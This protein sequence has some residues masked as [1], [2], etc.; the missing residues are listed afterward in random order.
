M[1]YII[2]V[3]KLYIAYH[4]PQII[5]TICKKHPIIKLFHFE[6]CLRIPFVSIK[7]HAYSTL[8]QQKRLQSG[9]DPPACSRYDV[10]IRF[11]SH[12]KNLKQKDDS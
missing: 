4:S 8:K 2:S 7:R 1:N 12:K 11:R 5:A 3:L 9:V 10:N 6:S